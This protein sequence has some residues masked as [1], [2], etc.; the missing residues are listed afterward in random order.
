MLAKPAGEIKNRYTGGRC[1]IIANGPSLA[2]HD[3][4]RIN[5]PTI[6]VNRSW[7]RI[8]SLYHCAVDPPQ[9]EAIKKPLKYL[10]TATGRAPLW[11]KIPGIGCIEVPGLNQRASLWKRLFH[12]RK[13]ELGWSWD[14]GKGAFYRG[15]TYF[16]LQVAAYIGFDKVFLIA[17]DLK[18]RGGAGHFYPGHS[19]APSMLK[20]Q[21]EAFELAARKLRGRVKVYNCNLDSALTVFP[22]VHF[23]DVF[24]EKMPDTPEDYRTPTTFDNRIY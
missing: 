1:A 4:L 9:I 21:T 18:P 12:R 24:P 15:T 2:D 10:F 6:G 11:D 14:L 22:K 20:A 19:M 23:E 3:L 5:C 16:A 13:Y 7:E 17:V 8:A